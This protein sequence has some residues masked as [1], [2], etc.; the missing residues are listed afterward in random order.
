MKTKKLI[1]GVIGAVVLILAGVLVHLNTSIEIAFESDFEDNSV[2]EYT[3]EDI[4]FPM[5][6]VAKGTGKI[7]S[8]DVNYEVVNLADNSI[9]EDK[10]ATFNLKCGE[11][12]FVCTYEDNSLIKREV[13]F[14]VQDTLS[15]GIEFTNIPNGVFLQDIEEGESPK[16][17]LYTIE[18]ASMD[19]GIELEKTLY[20]MGEED[21]DY[22]AYDYKEIN[23][24]YMPQAFGKFKYVLVA[25]DIHGNKTEA[26]E[27]YLADYSSEGY[28]N[29]IESGDANQY[30][31]IGDD[32]KDLWYEEFEGAKGVL[33]IDMGFNN[34]TG[35]GSNVIK[36]H[37][38]ENF[39]KKDIDGKYLAVRMYV[40]AENLDEEFLMSGN[41]V[42]LRD[43]QVTRAFYSQ[44]TGL[45]TGKWM[46]YYIDAETVQNIG[47]YDNSKY[48]SATTFY[49]GGDEASAIQLCFFRK[50]GFSNRMKLYVDSITLA[51]KLPETVVT[52]NDSTASWNAVDG[53]VGY[54]VNV[55][56]VETIVED[57]KFSLNEEVGYVRVIPLG[58][59][60]LTLDGEEAVAVFGLD[61]GSNLASFDSELYIDL[62]SEKLNFSSDAEHFGYKPKTMTG[63]YTDPGVTLELGTG[64]WGVCT[65]TK[66]L[67]PQ[68]KAKGTNTTLELNMS[69]SNAK[70]RVMRVY[71]YDGEFLGEIQLTSENTG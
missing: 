57:T 41:I 65:G 58:D 63:T 11:Y 20:F 70:Y 35:R 24:S 9:L 51:E 6:Y 12:K 26:A 66:I 32:Y 69:I 39:T 43:D 10:Y 36:L 45:E 23:N 29:L 56:G 17:P 1:A 55:N 14:T 68:A 16:L 50:A 49:Q 15:P 64:E 38:A 31:K 21:A 33:E 19:D 61:A 5:A 3:G 46:T 8:Y 40:D 52:V 27:G 37:F 62:F 54:K 34:A 18:D 30:Y 60:A 7:V 71:D 59:G 13:A 47:V 53:A 67:F 22:K 25:T 42:E 4:Q 28:T 2:I 44:I 48:N